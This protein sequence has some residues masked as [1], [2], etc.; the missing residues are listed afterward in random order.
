MYAA[1]CVLGWRTRN[2][3]I[4]QSLVIPF[5]MI[6]LDELRDDAPEVSLPDRNDP[7]ETFF[8]N[9]ADESLGVGIRVGSTIRR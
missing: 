1:G 9:R 4:A 2:E 3:P 8:L 6:V 7:V 5:V